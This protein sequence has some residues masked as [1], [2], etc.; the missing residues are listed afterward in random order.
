MFALDLHMIPVVGLQQVIRIGI[1]FQ[2]G[3][4]PGRI[5][6]TSLVTVVAAEPGRGVV[7]AAI[8]EVVH[9]QRI[10][11]H[12]DAAAP[13]SS[14]PEVFGLRVTGQPEAVHVAQPVAVLA[15]VHNTGV[16]LYGHVL[17]HLLLPPECQPLRRQDLTRV[18]TERHPVVGRL[19]LHPPEL[20]ELALV[21]SRLRRITCI[22]CGNHQ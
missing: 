15:F 3:R 9:L 18:A 13:S 14:C 6:H 7:V 5:V 20:I 17:T 4:T 16:I 8:A 1:F 12:E 22:C 19:R 10:A 21:E 11:S 2:N